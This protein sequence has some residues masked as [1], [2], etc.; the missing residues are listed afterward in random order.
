MTSPGFQPNCGWPTD[1][2]G[3]ASVHQI[4][5]YFRTL[6]EQRFAWE[7]LGPRFAEAFRQLA[8]PKAQQPI[9]APVP[10]NQRQLM[11]V[12]A[13]QQHPQNKQG[14]HNNKELGD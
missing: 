1:A 9:H 3:R 7:N 5:E 11:S 4:M 13:N 10:Q 2:S 14:Q 8:Q 6:Q 12:L